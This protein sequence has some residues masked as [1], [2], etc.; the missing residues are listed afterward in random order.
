MV[1]RRRI[2]YYRYLPT[3]VE[4]IALVRVEYWRGEKFG[5][6]LVNEAVMDGV[7]G[8]LEAVGNA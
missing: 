8:Q 4:F 2:P 1:R 7:Q 6:A 3:R 5:L